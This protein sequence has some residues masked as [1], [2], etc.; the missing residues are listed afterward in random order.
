[1][2]QFLHLTIAMRIVFFLAAIALG[3][4]PVKAVAKAFLTFSS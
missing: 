4:F 2:K 1:M 3:L